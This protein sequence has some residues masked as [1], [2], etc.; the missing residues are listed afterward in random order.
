M[1]ID[2][3]NGIVTSNARQLALQTVTA[4]RLD[5]GI[6]SVASLLKAA[7]EVEAFLTNGLLSTDAPTPE[8]KN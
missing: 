2:T 4:A 7:G 5:L 6:N 8:K 3:Q 1:R